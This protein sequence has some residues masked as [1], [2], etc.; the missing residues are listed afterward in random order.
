MCECVQGTLN[1]CTTTSWHTHINLTHMHTKYTR[2]YVAKIV[3]TF[4]TR[5]S[6]CWNEFLALCHICMSFLAQFNTQ[7]FVKATQ[8]YSLTWPTL[9]D[10]SLCYDCFLFVLVSLSGISVKYGSIWSGVLCGGDGWQTVV[11]FSKQKVCIIL[12][13]LLFEE[14]SYS[15]VLHTW[16]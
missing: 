6:S 10:D 14:I 11:C 13:K 7:P 15:S 5:D 16:L 1:R 3:L 8:W 2:S 12:P 4:T 9:G